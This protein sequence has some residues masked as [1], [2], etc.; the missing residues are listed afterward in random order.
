[1]LRLLLPIMMFLHKDT[2]LHVIVVLHVPHLSTC[3]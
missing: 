3:H 2:F 1:M